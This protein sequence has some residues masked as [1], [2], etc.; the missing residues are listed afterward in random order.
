MSRYALTK[1]ASLSG[2]FRVDWSRLQADGK[3]D[4]LLLDG[5]TVF[6]E[7]LVPS[8]RVD[9]EVRRPGMLNYV[10][11]TSVRDYV[12]QAGGFTNRAWTGKIR[13]TRAVTGQTM[14]ARNVPHLDPGDFVWVPEKPDV[15]AW[16]QSREILTALAQVAT[17]IIAIKSVN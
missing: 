14:L 10:S 12:K 7:R 5:D 4:L 3:L 17:V 11:G 2:S 15:T 9:G 13:V 1:L 8:I 16:E 6:V